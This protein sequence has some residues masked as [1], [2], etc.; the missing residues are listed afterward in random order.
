LLCFTGKEI[1]DIML[2]GDGAVSETDEYDIP[3]A[4]QDPITK[5]GDIW[6]LGKHRII[7]GDSTDANTVASLLDGAKP[8]IMVT[9]PPYGVEYDAS[10]RDKLGGGYEHATGKVINDD[11]ADWTQAWE[12][13]PGGVVYV[14]HSS[15]K[16]NVVADSLIRCGFELRSLI[17]WNKSSF[18]ISRGHYH[19]K[20][21]PCW[22][23]VRKGCTAHW[24]GDRKQST[25]WDINKPQ[26]SETGH[27]TQKPIECMSRPILNNSKIGQSIYEPFSGSGTTII[28][29]EETG[30][31]CYA[32][33]LNPAYVDVAVARW[34]K[35]T[36]NKAKLIERQS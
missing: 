21:E 9:D 3:E 19:D 22:Y 6:Q 11:T 33:E 5:P 15:K 27:S 10:W 32:V 24:N 26:K 31:I 1:D 35:L 23:A 17:V 16:S 7:C 12:L 4:P 13:F 28:A 20:H 34:E 8:H 18:A 2:S 14:W 29:A 36:G 30:K 25:V